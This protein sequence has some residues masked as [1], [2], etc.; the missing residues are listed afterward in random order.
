MPFGPASTSPESLSMTRRNTPV[1]VPGVSTRAI[2]PSGVQV[3]GGGQT[4]GAAHLEARE[5]SHRDARFL[6]HV[7]DLFL[8]VLDRVLLAEHDLLVEA[9]DGALD[10]LGDRLLGLAVLT[11]LGLGDASLTVEQLRGDLIPADVLRLHRGNLHRGAAGGNSVV[12]GELDE[13]A[14]LR[15]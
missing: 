14:D 1:P 7:L 11:S 10:D 6:Q 9:D 8:V 4:S 12:T 13:H 2:P 15:W 3:L 5:G